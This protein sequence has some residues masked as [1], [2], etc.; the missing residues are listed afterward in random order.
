MTGRR[1]SSEGG[2]TAVEMAIACSVLLLVAMMGFAAMR[3]TLSGSTQ[4]LAKSQ[5][6]TVS[7]EA[8][9]ELRLQATSAN[10]L[11]NPA[12]EGS[13]AGTNPD[14]SSIPAGFSLRIYT[15]ANGIR[16]C[17]QWRV[18]DTGTLQVRSWSNDWQT[19]GVVG[20]WTAL[21]TGITNPANTPPFVLDQG[22]NFGGAGSSRLLDIDFILGGKSIVQPVQVQSSIAGRN[23]EYFPQNSGVCSQMPTP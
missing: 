18:L 3:S 2:F 14:N 21:L 19:N 15:Q 16:T 5:A 11:Y 7:G 6:T 9:N 10:V 13:N 23:A 1:A 17:M 12:T 8:L 20:K 22:A 4:D